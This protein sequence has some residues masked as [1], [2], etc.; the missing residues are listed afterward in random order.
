MANIL[1]VSKLCKE[2]D[3]FALKDVSFE[4]GQG[5]AVCLL[6]ER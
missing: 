1:E 2:Y 4:V 5:E 6:V 3:H